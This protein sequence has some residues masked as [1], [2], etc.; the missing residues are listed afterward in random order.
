MACGAVTF[1]SF[2]VFHYFR[3]PLGGAVGFLRGHIMHWTKKESL[4]KVGDCRTGQCLLIQRMLQMKLNRCS[5]ICEDNTAPHIS[6]VVR[7]YVARIMILNDARH[8]HSDTMTAIIA[9]QGTAEV[10][11][12]DM[13]FSEMLKAGRAKTHQNFVY[14]IYPNPKTVLTKRREIRLL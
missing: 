14:C 9:M 3:L 4:T 7:M 12:I 6:G 1:N 8:R 10:N 5:N 11:L 2:E 13:L